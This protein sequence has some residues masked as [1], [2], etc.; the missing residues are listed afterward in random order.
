MNKQTINEADVKQVATSIYQ[1]LHKAD[2]DEVI[3]LYPFEQEQDPSATWNLVV[4]KIIFDVVNGAQTE[5]NELI[6]K[7]IERI[8]QDIK[9]GDVTVIDELLRYIP[10]DNLK[11]YLV[12]D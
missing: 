6:D 8:K 10:V 2:I 3:K 5:L 4:E 9:V 11:G 7:V 1:K 12:E